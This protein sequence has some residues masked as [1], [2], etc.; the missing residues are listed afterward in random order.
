M[1][2]YSYIVEILTAKKYLERVCWWLMKKKKKKV[3]KGNYQFLLTRIFN[4]QKYSRQ[5]FDHSRNDNSREYYCSFFLLDCTNTCAV[6]NTTAKKQ[7]SKL[8]KA[9]TDKFPLSLCENRFSKIVYKYRQNPPLRTLNY[10][11]PREI[12]GQKIHKNPIS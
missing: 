4:F 5:F 6:P 10:K 11:H 7:L 1:N 8:F 12:D 3:E 9:M 2:S